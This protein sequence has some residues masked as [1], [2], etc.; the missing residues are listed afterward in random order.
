[1]QRDKRT[2]DCKI[3]TKKQPRVPDPRRAK[4]GELIVRK[5]ASPTTSR[6]VAGTRRSKGG[7]SRNE[8]KK[9]GDNMCGIGRRKSGSEKSNRK[10]VCFC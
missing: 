2:G 7:F 1:V 4:E 9:E 8:E 5:K 6:D 3:G 10:P